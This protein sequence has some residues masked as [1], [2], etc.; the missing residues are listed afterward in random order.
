MALRDY[1]LCRECDMKLIYDGY[2]AI[3]DA[4][5][6]RWGDPDADDWTIHAY[7]PEHSGDGSIKLVLTLQEH[8][9]EVK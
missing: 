5:E 7:C 1:I 3:R 4:L 9:R 8:A 6:E 2:D